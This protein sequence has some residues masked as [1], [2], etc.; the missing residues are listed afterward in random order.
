MFWLF[1]SDSPSSFRP[2]RPILF[3]SPDVNAFR[4]LILIVS[5]FFSYTTPFR[6]FRP[7]SAVYSYRSPF[8]ILTPL[9][10]CFFTPFSLPPFIRP[11]SY[12][13][14]YLL[15]CLSTDLSTRLLVCLSVYL[16]THLHKCLYNFF[17]VCV[18]V[19]GT[20]G[21]LIYVYVHYIC[22]DVNSGCDSEIIGWRD[23]G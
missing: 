22:T 9:L 4:V 2:A 1:F 7:L 11:C 13:P 14:S 6:I 18:F 20:Y 17:Y 15:T 5:A 19:C 21:L 10:P 12:V 23:N 8:F 16:Y 3:G